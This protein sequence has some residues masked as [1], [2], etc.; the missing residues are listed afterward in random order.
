[1][2]PLAIP[3]FNGVFTCITSASSSSAC[4]VERGS[5]CCYLA[6]ARSEAEM[7][8]SP[9]SLSLWSHTSLQTYA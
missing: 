2:R 5:K 1:M 8:G 6:G 9:F 3:F 7:I 4:S